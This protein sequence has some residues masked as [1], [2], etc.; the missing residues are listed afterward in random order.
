MKLTKR[1][2]TK[3][4]VSTSNGMNLIKYHNELKAI[5]LSYKIF[6]SAQYTQT[7]YSL[8]NFLSAMCLYYMDILH[9]SKILEVFPPLCQQLSESHLK[10][11]QACQQRSAGTAT[12]GMCCLQGQQPLLQFTNLQDNM[13]TSGSFNKL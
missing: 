3:K 5:L 10:F 4:F 8:E 6:S 11:L 7:L 2:N 13:H 1:I 12:Q 9:L